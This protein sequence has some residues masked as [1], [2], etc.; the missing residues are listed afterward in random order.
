MSQ[1]HIVLLL[2]LLLVVPRAAGAQADARTDGAPSVPL[3]IAGLQG[4]V[5]LVRNGQLEAVVENTV[6]VSGDRLRAGTGRAELRDDA[7]H[8]IYVDEASVVDVL[9]ETSIR[10][11]A[12]SLRV[13][14]AASARGAFRIDAP[15]ATVTI[16]APGDY[17]LR[18]S[19]GLRT[20]ETEL[21]VRDGRA[22]FST[23]RGAVQVGPGQV[24]VARG[25]AAPDPPTAARD[26]RDDFDAWADTRAEAYGET[27][28]SAQLPQQIASY[29]AV[30]DQ[31][32]T[33]A[34]EP[35][36]GTV[37]YPSVAADWRPYA[38][39]SWGHA[40]YYG[41]VWVGQGPWAWPTHHYGRWGW[42][43]G[44]WFWVPGP[45]WGPAWVSWGVG[46]DYVGWCPLGW[47][48]LPVFGFSVGVGYYGGGYG[49]YGYYGG[50]GGYGWGWTVVP[51][52]YFRPGVPAW[53]HAVDH[54]G[55]GSSERHGF[56]TQRTPPAY[57]GGP[58]YGGRP[59]GDRGG[60]GGHYAVPRYGGSPAPGRGQ[61]GTAP[62]PSPGTPPQGLDGPRASGAPQVYGS[63]QAY[64]SRQPFTSGQPR[65]S[66]NSGSEARSGQRGIGSQPAL[67]A[68]SGRW[69]LP[70]SGVGAGTS[71]RA[72]PP[73]ARTYRSYQGSVSQSPR[74][75]PPSA[76]TWSSRSPGGSAAGSF[77]RAPGS[78]GSSRWTS[79]VPSVGRTPN[80]S[81]SPGRYQA[82]SYGA[83]SVPSAPRSTPAFHS[84]GGGGS[85]GAPPASGGGG[86]AAMPRG[87]PGRR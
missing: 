37:W 57:R 40:G 53:R 84:P 50:H 32:G 20:D 56:V 26:V 2:G 35:Q 16:S 52:H 51:S 9:S 49:S 28:S 24:S 8:A 55:W 87:G 5:D 66:Q 11:V 6:L 18:V 67:P 47:N 23:D 34:D 72:V 43:G 25:T 27:A 74:Y 31:Y 78:V 61:P 60:Y 38:Y 33:W 48:D 1:S 46:S 58:G 45:V 42:N 79:G 69:A 12:G 15:N 71:Y 70:R 41:S 10:L 36:Y 86:R 13:A 30:L 83:R 3:Y 68:G 17:R 54:R 59:A 63:G 85:R 4:P 29:G 73:P 76:S 44:A 14:A 19:A 65:A 77:Q 82:P 7:G 80:V 21:R 62:R 22:A 39:G 75:G 64:V 81:A